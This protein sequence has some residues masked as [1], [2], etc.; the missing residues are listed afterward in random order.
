MKSLSL[1]SLALCLLASEAL[2]ADDLTGPT[3]RAAVEAR[4]PD[5]KEALSAPEA[6]LAQELAT[7]GKG[8]KVTVWFGT[9]CGDSRREVSR[10]FAALATIKGKPAFAL[11]LVAVPRGMAGAPPGMRYVPTFIV[12]RGEQELGRIVESAPRGLV[13][14]L[15]ALLSGA[16]TGVI[17]GRPELQPKSVSGVHPGSE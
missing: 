4:F 7:A 8:L 10:L 5:W 11:E 15:L 16:K 3:T 9:W 6:A 2:A 17:S 1:V 12:S 13:R 14:E